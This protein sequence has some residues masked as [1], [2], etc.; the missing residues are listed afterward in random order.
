MACLVLVAPTALL[1]GCASPGPPRPPSLHLPEP[2]ADLTASRE[3]DAVELHFTLPQHTTDSLPIREGQVVASLCR[4][5][6]T[7]VC[8]LVA[9]FHGR[10]MPIA[11]A[12]GAPRTVTWR[13]V[14][15]ASLASGDPRVLAYRV[16]LTNMSG[17]SAGWS[18]PAYAAAGVAPPDVG[19][20][21]AEGTRKGILLHWQPAAA[22]ESQPKTE[23][24]LRRDLTASP[25]PKPR[26]N[27]PTAR[28]TSKSAAET[29]V[30]LEAH[31]DGETLDASAEQ[32]IPYRYTAVR[33][34]KVKI[35]DRYFELRSASSAPVDITLRDV[36]PPAAPTGLSAA[37]FREAGHFAVDLVWNP[38]EDPELAG[39]T[40]MR[41][42]IDLT[43][44]PLGPVQKLNATP[45]TL[46]AFHDT[47]ADAA[48]RY[49]YTVTAV[50]RKGNESAAATVVVEPT[51]ASQ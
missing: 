42:A 7:Q 10:E 19:G 33:S 41:Q 30:W 29:T 9:G 27:P 23:V 14:L 50:D 11:A 6:E 32:D 25:P 37:P 24:L 16:E 18:L 48:T 22:G 17:K 46:P 15:P 35:G 44:A 38:V 21:A 39:Y 49:R 8:A 1:I 5:P 2:V 51:N 3:G 4:A 40:V 34:H 31:S 12:S 45:A 36:F 43:G 28:R 47:S 20:L 13:D 26:A